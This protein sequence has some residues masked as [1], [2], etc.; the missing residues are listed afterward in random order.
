KR[1]SRINQCITNLHSLLVLAQ[2]KDP[3]H[4]Q[5]SFCSTKN[6]GVGSVVAQHEESSWGMAYRGQSRVAE[7]FLLRGLFPTFRFDRNYD[8]I[9]GNAGRAARPDRTGNI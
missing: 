4:S 3:E 9:I 1:F 2:A 8:H 7:K 6:V 5:S